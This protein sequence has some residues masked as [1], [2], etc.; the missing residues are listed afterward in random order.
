MEQ[1]EE[2]DG[3]SWTATSRSSARCRL[4]AMRHSRAKPLR[5][6]R[7]RKSTDA[8]PPAD[9]AACCP[10]RSPRR[11]AASSAAGTPS[12]RQLDLRSE[13]GCKPRGR[14]AHPIPTNRG[15]AAAAGVS[16]RLWSMKSGS[17]HER[18]AATTASPRRPLASTADHSV[19]ASV[20]ANEPPPLAPAVAEAASC[21]LGFPPPL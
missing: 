19:A 13:L 17:R 7:P 6:S 8:L 5:L 14:H 3:C 4:C 1:R 18:D 9:R 10:L 12:L 20:A 11:R 16:S 21:H 2:A 15:A